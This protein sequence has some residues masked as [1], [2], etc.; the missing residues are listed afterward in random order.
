LLAA[1]AAAGE[2]RGDIEPM[3]LLRAVANL[4]LPAE[5]DPG[6]TERMVALLVDGLRYGAGPG[7]RPA[8]SR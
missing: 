4:C 7:P 2:I 6:G 1:A 8:G 3:E 5:V